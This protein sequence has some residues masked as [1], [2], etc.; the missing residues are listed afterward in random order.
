MADRGAVRGQPAADVEGHGNDARGHRAREVKN[1]F[2][3]EDRERARL[4][5][6]FAYA[7]KKRLRRHY[8]RRRRKVGMAKAEELRPQRIVAPVLGADVAELRERVEAA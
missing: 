5:H 2:A 3:L 4:V 8:E 1:F 7:I 6:R